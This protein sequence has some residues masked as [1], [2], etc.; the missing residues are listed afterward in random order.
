LVFISLDPIS[1]MHLGLTNNPDEH[2]RAELLSHF[3]LRKIPNTLI[4]DE[5]TGRECF[6]RKR[7]SEK[8]EL[9]RSQKLQAAK[10][11]GGRPAQ[12]AGARANYFS[13]RIAASAV[14]PAED[15]DGESVGFE[16]RVSVDS[17]N[18]AAANDAIKED[19]AMTVVD[20]DGAVMPFVPVSVSTGAN[21]APRMHTRANKVEAA[22]VEVVQKF[23]AHKGPLPPLQEMFCHPDKYLFRE[24]GL[25]LVD[26]VAVYA[27]VTQVGCV[28]TEKFIAF[29]KEFKQYRPCT[30]THSS[31]GDAG[32]ASHADQCSSRRARVWAE[33]LVDL[34]VPSYHAML[35]I[36]TLRSH[37]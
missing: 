17:G 27:F 15:D 23:S 22:R 12:G 25:S 19:D 4:I 1:S 32:S 36:Q 29:L 20:M 11:P 10:R 31:N 26:S 13:S 28:T 30:C 16:T 21:A 3:I 24:A 35:V 2:N 34:G 6:L 33:T 8:L 37:L 9:T 18:T 7:E 5:K 14:V